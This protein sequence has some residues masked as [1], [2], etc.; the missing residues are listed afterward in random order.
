MSRKDYK[1]I[2]AVLNDRIQH[3][4]KLVG[5]VPDGEVDVRETEVRLVAMKLSEVFAE[6]NDRF[7]PNLFMDA[8]TGI[9][10]NLIR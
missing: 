3:I 1:K 10:T 5:V 2:A 7:N 4:H 9:N 6:D 8:V